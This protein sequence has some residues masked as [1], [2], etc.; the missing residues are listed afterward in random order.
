MALLVPL[1]ASTAEGRGAVA[2]ATVVAGA[3]SGVFGAASMPAVSALAAPST[4]AI[5]VG[6]GL[7]RGLEAARGWDVCGSAVVAAASR[8][9]SGLAAKISTSSTSFSSTFSE[10]SLLEDHDTSAPIP[11][12]PAW[13]R[14][15]TRRP[16]ATRMSVMNR[17]P[18][19]HLKGL[20]GVDVEIADARRGLAREA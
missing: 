7:P 17:E 4:S 9:G 10:T 6:C 11:N 8:T 3:T 13:Q 18:A 5:V 14:T 20:G 16:A 2:V 19:A 15:A 12:R 1:R